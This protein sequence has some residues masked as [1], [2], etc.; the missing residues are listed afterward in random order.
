MGAS[1]RMA[2]LASAFCGNHL[3]AGSHGRSC[4]SR[5]RRV[6]DPSFFV[7]CGS[8]LVVG[9]CCGF[10]V[11]TTKRSSVSRIVSRPTGKVI[12]KAWSDADYK[13]V[14]ATCGVPAGVAGRTGRLLRL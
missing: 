4:T 14:A 3:S 9:Q 13:V 7:F 8:R 6:C 2:M 11:G 10:V 5:L 1:V 12:A